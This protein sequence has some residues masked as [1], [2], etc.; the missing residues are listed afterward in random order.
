MKREKE[1]QEKLRHIKCFGCGKLG[2]YKNMCQ[3]KDDSEGHE[4]HIVSE[5][6]DV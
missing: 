3:D 2:H 4:G 1:Q 5:G 6:I